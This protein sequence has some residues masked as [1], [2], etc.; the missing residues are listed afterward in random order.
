MRT[1]ATVFAKEVRIT[2][3]DRKTLVSS[4]L[5]PALAIPL[6]L[7]GVSTLGRRLNEQEASKK[8][9]VALL[10]APPEAR[11]YFADSTLLLVDAASPAAAQDSIRAE[12]L[13]AAIVF[14]PGF[15]DSVARM[16]TGRVRLYHKSTQIRTESRLTAKLDHYKAALTTARL[17]GLNLPDSLMTP[18]ALQ[19]TDL[20]SKQEQIGTLAGGFLPYIFILFCF[21]GSLYP[22][23]DIVTGEKEKGTLETLL[24]SPAARLHILLGKVL[25]IASIGV[26]A[27]LMG[28]AGMFATLRLID[29]IPPEILATLADILT[30]RFVLMLFAM[31]LPLSLFFAGVLS[32]IAIRAE[33]FKEAQSYVTPLSFVVI[34]PAA[35]AMM[36]G[37]QLDAQTAWIPVLNLALATK[38]IIAGTIQPLHYAIVVGSLAAYAL[39]AVLISIRQF[40]DEKNILK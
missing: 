2:L 15:A 36:P 30:L 1:I 13:D 5:I 12:A 6:L 33:S 21:L 19:Q 7:L 16:G 18:L 29:E 8:L 37:L 27:A 14:A 22:A 10:G 17:R 9:K 31:L 32:A 28:I 20:A 4:I 3:R 39:A 24:T 11:P 38:Q 40:G 34:L 23:L 25:A 35:R 26:A